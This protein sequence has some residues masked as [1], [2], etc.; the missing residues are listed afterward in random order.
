MPPDT[1][2]RDRDDFRPKLRLVRAT[3]PQ[4]RRR[5]GAFGRRRIRHRFSQVTGPTFLTEAI[6]IALNPIDKPYA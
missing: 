4:A 3:Q 2:N 6:D 1:G 5:G